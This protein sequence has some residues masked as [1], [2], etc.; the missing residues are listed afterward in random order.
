MGG[1]LRRHGLPQIGCAW[2]ILFL[3]DGGKTWQIG[4]SLHQPRLSM[5]PPPATDGRLCLL[6]L[7]DKLQIKKM[8]E[9]AHS[10]HDKFNTRDSLV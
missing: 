3:V 6:I 7:E 10:V 1:D 9:L 2:R 8:R 5:R 4:R